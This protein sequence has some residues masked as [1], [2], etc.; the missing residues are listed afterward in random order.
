VEEAGTGP[1][2]VLAH[3]FGGSAR[4]FRPQARAF[5]DRYRVVLYDARGHARSEAPREPA[6]YEPECFVKDLLAVVDRTG[7]QSVV[8][9]GLSMGAGV[10]LRFALAHRERVRGLVLAAF[11]SP[12]R[13]QAGRPWALAFADAIDERGVDAAGSEFVWGERSRFD[14]DG[15]RLIRQGFLEHPRH[16]LSSTLRHLLAAQP[17]VA[18]MR[19]QLADLA[20]PVLLVVGSRDAGSLEVTQKLAQALPAPE[21]VVVEG[22][23][24]V[25]NL[26]DVEAFNAALTHFLTRLP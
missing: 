6:Q 10:A 19:D 18:A 2:V 9:G 12:P 3:G 22:A 24:H 21:L 11:P 7:E 5:S 25:V 15:A 17:D 20:M 1:V 4:N 13:S 8:V 26:A 16:A 23:G 14:P